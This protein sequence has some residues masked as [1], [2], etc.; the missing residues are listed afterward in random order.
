MKVGIVCAFDT[1]FD[2]V[3]LLKEYYEEK[4]AEVKVY[5]SDF[6]H[7]LTHI[8]ADAVRHRQYIPPPH[9]FIQYHNQNKI[10]NHENVSV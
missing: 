2:R 1:Y 6:S 10:N 9:R 3:S 4:G 8:Y 7:F 5:S